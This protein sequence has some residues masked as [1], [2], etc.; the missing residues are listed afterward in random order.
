MRHDDGEGN[1]HQGNTLRLY[2]RDDFRWLSLL[3]RDFRELVRIGRG[4]L[5]DCRNTFLHL[6]IR[7]V[8]GRLHDIGFGT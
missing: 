4:M 7:D 2:R 6:R 5:R 8:A 3:L 1:R